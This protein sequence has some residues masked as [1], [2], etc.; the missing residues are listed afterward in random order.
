MSATA[1][2]TGAARFDPRV[3]VF[4]CNWCSYAG[5]DTAGVSRLAQTASP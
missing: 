3:L 2:G 1:N 4:A 5:A